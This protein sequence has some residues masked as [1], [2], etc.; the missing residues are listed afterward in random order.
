MRQIYWDNITPDF[1]FVAKILTSGYIPLSAVITK[2]KF[3]KKIYNKFERLL[4]GSTFQGH[5]LG[6]AAAIATQ[7]IVTEDKM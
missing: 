7:K 4:H 1:I 2:K 3:A 5:S 6:V